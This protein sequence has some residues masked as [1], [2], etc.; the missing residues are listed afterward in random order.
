MGFPFQHGLQATLMAMRLCELLEVD[1][2]TATQTYYVCMLIYTG[3]TTDAEEGSQIFAGEQTANTI[4]VLFASPLERA[5]GVIRALPPPGANPVVRTVEI[6]RRLPRAIR[7]NSAHQTALC[8]VAEMLAMRLGLPPAIHGQFEFLTERWDGRGVLGRAGGDDIP[9]A[10]RI[11]LLARDAAFQNQIGGRDHAARTIEERAGGAFDPHVARSFVDEADVVLSAADSGTD[12]WETVLG[13][14]PRPHLML[15]GHAIDRALGAIGDFSDLIHSSL[16]GHSAGVADLSEKAAEIAGLSETQKVLVRRAALIHDAGRVA[17]DP[18]IWAKE[19]PL[20]VDE[21][22]KVRLHPYHTERIFSRSGFLQ[23]PAAVA[24]RH[25]ERL[26]GSGYHRGLGA[27][28]L[29]DTAR[30]LA[31]ADTF[32]AMTE[33]RPFR[34]SLMPDEA[35]DELTNLGN[36]GRLDP[37]MVEA[38]IEAAGE[39]ARE[40]GRPAGLTPREAEVLGLI[41]RGLQ[42]KQVARRLDISKKTTDTHIQSAYRKIGVSTRAAATLYAM[43]H[44]LVPPDPTRR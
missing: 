25:H 20:S 37:K 1:D 23:Q 21:R 39:P 22:E 33:P 38:V 12:A 44:G 18:R 32:Q 34:E 16:S 24:G 6:A 15:E 19:G 29:S 2:D 17:V 42:T 8:E 3:C 14:E 27:Q 13:C 26:N 28:S 10:T 43:E 31:A 36:S 7:A 40:I 4:P 5:L 9:T 30:L 41:A 35:A 11:A